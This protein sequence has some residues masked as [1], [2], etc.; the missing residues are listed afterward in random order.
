M[1]TPATPQINYINDDLTLNGVGT[2]YGILVVTGTL[3]M[4]GNFSWYG[5]V[6]IVGD[7]DLEFSGGGTGS[8]YGTVLA[9]KIWDSRTSVAC[10]GGP[11]LLSSLGSPTIH[12]NGGG[13]NGIY[14]DHCW[15]TDLM[16]KVYFNP[17]VSTKPL[18]VLSLRTLPY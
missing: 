8:I 18:K 6:L 5:T 12:W 16:S 14:Y 2:G 9:A 15:A 1:G 7:G 10:N 17:P 3:R 11:C 13:N 4:S